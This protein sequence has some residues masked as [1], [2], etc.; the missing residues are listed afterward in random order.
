M[1]VIFGE[2]SYTLKRSA[3]IFLIFEYHR[4]FRVCQKAMIEI[5]WKITIF[6]KRF[7]MDVKHD[8]NKYICTKS[9]RKT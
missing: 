3:E 2:K 5:F 8:S 6:A 4:V 9:R 7:V 1:L